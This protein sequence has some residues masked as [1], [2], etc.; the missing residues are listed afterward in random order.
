M[1]QHAPVQL[2]ARLQRTRKALHDAL[3]SLLGAKTFDQISIRELTARAGVG[4]ATFYRRYACKEDLL[5]ELAEA[6]V[7]KLMEVA[8]PVV[9]TAGMRESYRMLCRVVEA[10]RQLWRAMLSGPT[11]G[12]LRDEF[13]QRIRRLSG[14]YVAASGAIPQE[15]QLICATG[16]TLDV[17]AWWLSQRQPPSAD[18]V[19]DILDH[20][21]GALAP[22]GH[23]PPAR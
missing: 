22:G 9:F 6:E 15:L 18:E 16:A 17:L 23:R 20:V 2:D 8:V 19:V 11:S 5:H 14:R 1:L 7:Q 3:L 4:H 10:N 12:V 21:I 13:I